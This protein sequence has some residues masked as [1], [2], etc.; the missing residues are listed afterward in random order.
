MRT[1]LTIAIL[2]F[3]LPLCAASKKERALDL[4]VYAASELDGATTYAALR[5]CGSRCYEA[6]P[7]MQP[8]ASTPAIFPVMALGAVGVNYLAQ[9]LRTRH[10]RIAFA[11]QGAVIG[12][13]LFAGEHNL[14]AA[15]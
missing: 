9:R 3:A 2:L 10:G 13:H 15:Q 8:V 14:T 6:N 12:V 11:L 5:D 1:A 4:A 7:F